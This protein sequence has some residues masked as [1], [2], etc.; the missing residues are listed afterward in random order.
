[1]SQYNKPP[2]IDRL[3]RGYYRSGPDYRKSQDV[4]FAEIRK[5]FGFRSIQIG[6]WVTRQEQQIAANLIYDALMDLANI[7][8]VPAQVLS[9]RGSLSL[10][11]GTGGQ[12][13]V[14]A[15]Y[16]MRKR[17]LALA[18]NAGGGA[19]AH[20][21]FHAFDHYINDKLFQ[22]PSSSF[23]SNS[24]IYNKENIEHPLNL[25]LTQFYQTIFLAEDGKQPSEYLKIS[26]KIDQKLNQY[27]FAMPEELAAR[28]FESVI[29]DQPIKNAYLV[30]GTQ[31]SEQAELGIFPSPAHRT[32][33]AETCLAYFRL[34]GRLV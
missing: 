25:K 10:A 1:M 5:L 34:L 21:W 12:K 26:S 27:Y 9:L 14:Q 19:L 6:H 20:E 11:F 2:K 22:L 15:H 17:E 13:Y 30:C 3:K 33:L 8:A 18:K 29:Q 23:A 31:K 32:K 16:D 28:A 24:W 7:L 4:G